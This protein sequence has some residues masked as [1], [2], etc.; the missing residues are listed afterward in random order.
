MDHH[1]TANGQIYHIHNVALYMD[2]EI[3]E[4]IHARLA[5]CSAQE[6]WDAYAEADPDSDEVLALCPCRGI[7]D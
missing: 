5:P 6:F 2:D 1:F 7:D 3:R 4:A